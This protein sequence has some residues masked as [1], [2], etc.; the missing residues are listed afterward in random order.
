MENEKKKKKNPSI[1]LRA[2]ENNDDDDLSLATFFLHHSRRNW[3]MNRNLLNGEIYV[4]V[5]YEKKENKGKAKARP[6]IERKKGKIYKSPRAID[7]GTWA[8]F[9]ISDQYLICKLIRKRSKTKNFCILT[10]FPFN[11]FFKIQIF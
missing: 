8:H 1:E 6:S 2:N 4:C 11:G 5:W 10:G 7:R 9:C 3:I